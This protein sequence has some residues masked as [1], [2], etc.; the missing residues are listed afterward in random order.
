MQIKRSEKWWLDRARREGDAPVSAGAA[1]NCGERIRSLRAEKG[2]TLDA[3][4]KLAGS[5][6]SYIWELENRN[7]PRPSGEKLAKIAAALATTVDYLLG[8][9]P[10]KA[11]AEDNAFFQLY[12]T[13]PDLTRSRIR[14]VVRIWAGQSD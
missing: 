12:L 10:S 5:S 11:S 2:L 1:I 4:A 9:D 3:L 7:P 13:L 6:K 14:D 8:A